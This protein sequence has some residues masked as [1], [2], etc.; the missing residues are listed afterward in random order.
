MRMTRKPDPHESA[1][2]FAAEEF[3]RIADEAFARGMCMSCFFETILG[4]A[5]GSLIASE[6][7]GQKLYDVERAETLAEYLFQEYC[8]RAATGENIIVKVAMRPN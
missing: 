2:K 8:D 5:F 7:L 6:T 3:S 1:A 4:S